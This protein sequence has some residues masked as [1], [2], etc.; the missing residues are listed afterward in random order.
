MTTLTA[1]SVCGE[2]SLLVLAVH[3][4]FLNLFLFGRLVLDRFFPRSPGCPGICSVDKIGLE[5]TELSASAS[6]VLGLKKGTT[7][8]SSAF[9][10]FGRDN[11][12][13]LHS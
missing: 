12:P 5:L 6:R 10:F 9:E 7:V 4:I 13:Y 3:H 1:N 8:P 2:I 11:M